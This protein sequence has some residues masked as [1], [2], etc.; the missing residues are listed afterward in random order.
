MSSKYEGLPNVL[1]ECL[2]LKIPI[3]SS[4][5]PTGPYEILNGNKYGT[6]FHNNNVN[7]LSKLIIKFK[8]KKKFFLKK[9]ELGYKSLERFNFQKKCNE[10]LNISKSLF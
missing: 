5:C 8:F 3:I 10:Y 7:E 6:L 1:L 2:A 9:T 4:N